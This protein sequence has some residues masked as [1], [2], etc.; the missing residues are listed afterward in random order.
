[1]YIYIYIHVHAL[2]SCLS[3]VFYCLKLSWTIGALLTEWPLEINYYYYYYYY[4]Y[5]YYHY[6]YS[7]CEHVH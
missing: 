3:I 4:H 2:V 5:Y 1:M 6:Y 7:F